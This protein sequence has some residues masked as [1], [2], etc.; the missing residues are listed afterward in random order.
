MKKKNSNS[1]SIFN[2]F[3][4]CIL[5]I[6]ALL[7]IY[8]IWYV[9]TASLSNGNLIMQHSGLLLLPIKPNI[10]AYIAVFKNKMILSG[11]LN[12]IKIL[13]ISLILQITMTSIGAYFFSRE[14]VLFK[15]PL[16]FIITLTMF[17]SGGMIPFY[18]NLRSLHLMN[19]HWGLI[20]PF[21]IS[22]YN[23]IIL[24]TSFESI[25]KSLSEAAR[26]DG[27]GHIRILFS[28]VLPLSKPVLAVM[29]LYYGVG[30][31]NGW[32]WASTILTDRSMYPLQVILR[33][34][35]LSNDTSVMTQGVSSG[36]LEA[37]GATIRY[38]TVIVATLPILC[39]YPFLQKYFTKGIM[40]G[41]VKE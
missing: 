29:L 17:I 4:I 10:A 35:L 19:S 27:A 37:V 28:I 18:Q 40:I 6:L 33:E 24:K 30:V 31:W 11:Y 39:A 13:I 36:D 32:F 5:S 15:K 2:L 34:I 22:T 8:P 25:P 1:F 12:T 7:C 41:A 16:M 20:L 23:M 26:I 9:L 21:M 14:R 38:A 3:N